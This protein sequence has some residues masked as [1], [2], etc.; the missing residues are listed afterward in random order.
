MSH[1]HS[2]EGR[3]ILVTGGA[4]GIGSPLVSLLRNRGALVTT[5]GRGAMPGRHI[6]ADLST[7]AGIM[8]AAEQARQLAPQMLFNIAG[9]QYFG[10]LE[11][12]RQTDLLGDYLVNLVA[13]VT[14]TQAVLPAM[15]QRGRGHIINVGSVF[16][17]INFAHFAGYSSA[18]A[19]LKGFSQALRRE[20]RGT[21][22]TVCHIAPRAVRT[23]FNGPLVQRFA[24]LTGMA[25]DDPV[26]VAHRV[27]AAMQTGKAETVIGWPEAFFTRLN[28]LFPGLVGRALAAND[29]KAASL[30]TQAAPPAATPTTI[31][32]IREET[33]AR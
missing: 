30:F 22:I 2:L 29:A 15:K 3:T 31:M 7:E 25:Q 5:L 20:V 24:A 12:Q 32:P 14:L 11:G 17:A 1:D 16:G 6:R 21:G 23:G 4:G 9:R 13:P 18:K 10:P 33:H 26:Y 27:I 8:E 28:A 19:G